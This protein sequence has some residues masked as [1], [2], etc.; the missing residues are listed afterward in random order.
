MRRGTLGLEG[1]GDG[2]LIRFLFAVEDAEG[3]KGLVPLSHF[4][5]E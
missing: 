4:S 1:T 2:S 3:D 5:T